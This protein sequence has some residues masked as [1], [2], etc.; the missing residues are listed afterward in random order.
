MLK[1]GERLSV[2]SIKASKQIGALLLTVVMSLA[3]LSGVG[4]DSAEAASPKLSVGVTQINGAPLNLAMTT[5]YKNKTVVIELGTLVKKKLKY[6]RLTSVLL[7]SSGA[8]TLCTQTVLPSTSVLRVKY[9]SKIIATTKT[10]TRSNISACPLIAP[11]SVDLASVSDSGVSQTDNITNATELVINGIAFPNSTVTLLDAGVST[12]LTATAGVDG[13]YSITVSS[14]PTAGVHSYTTQASISGLTSSVSA[15]LEVTI[16][17]TKPTLN[18]GWEEGEIGPNSFKH[19]NL[20]PSEPIVG[21]ELSDVRIPSDPA[22]SMLVLSN[23]VKTGEDYR[24]TVAAH[25]YMATDLQF[26]M[27]A[28][29]VTDLAGNDSAGTYTFNSGVNA[30]RRV[31][32]SGLATLDIY[33]PELSAGSLELVDA[34]VDY[35]KIKFSFDEEVFDIQLSDLGLRQ[36]S[37]GFGGRSDNGYQPISD[38]STDGILHTTNNKDF[39]VGISQL[40]HY[41]FTDDAT[42]GITYEVIV[43]GSITDEYGNTDAGGN[44]GAFID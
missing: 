1:Q 6:T 3:M 28:D 23:L 26:T 35:G 10:K 22:F 9:G 27:W 5:K 36:W 21:F 18:W 33:R 20:V 11:A 30:G 38:Y 19:M 25:D 16:D 37:D 4:V 32:I 29:A 24:F 14:S 15:A 17:R 7:S 44:Y 12:G 2:N 39:W 43:I 13:A 34:V 8:A 41:F 42:R 40:Q 31:T